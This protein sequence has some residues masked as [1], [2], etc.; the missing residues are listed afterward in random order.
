MCVLFSFLKLIL[1]N[2]IIIFPFFREISAA[3]GIPQP[4]GLIGG[5][6]ASLD[7][8][9]SNMGFESRLQP[10]PQLTALSSPLTI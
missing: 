4:R 5:E 3:Y 7:H 2:F 1:F 8:S 10:A 6:A 9:H